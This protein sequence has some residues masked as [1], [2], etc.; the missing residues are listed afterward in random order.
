MALGHTLETPRQQQKRLD[1]A[2]LEAD[3]QRAERLGLP[4]EFSMGVGYDERDQYG[5]VVFDHR[6]TEAEYRAAKGEEIEGGEV[7]HLPARPRTRQE[8]R[9]NG[10]HLI[11]VAS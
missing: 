4:Q 11:R 6:P 10:E 5:G 9:R 1:A 8:N 3:R 7:V 2:Q